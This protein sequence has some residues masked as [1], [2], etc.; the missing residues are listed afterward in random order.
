MATAQFGNPKAARCAGTTKAGEPCPNVAVRFKESCW[1][2]APSLDNARRV[3]AQ[4]RRQ[5]KWQEPQVRM[6][7]RWISKIEGYMRSRGY[8]HTSGRFKGQTNIYQLSRESG[9]AYGMLHD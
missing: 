8:V 4:R 1:K 9:I 3:D 6:S 5:P 2:H 7:G